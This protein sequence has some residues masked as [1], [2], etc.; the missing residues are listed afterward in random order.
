MKLLLSILIFGASI[1]VAQADTAKKPPVIRIDPS[2]AVRI[3]YGYPAWNKSPTEIDSGSL[4]MR[5]KNSGRLV[6]IH[7]LETEPDSSAFSGL[8]SIN[9]QNVG[10]MQADFFIPPQ[11]LLNSPEGMKQISTMIANGQ[12]LRKPFIFRR[13]KARG[14]SVEIFDTRDQARSAMQAYVAEQQ[15]QGLQNDK[16]PSDSQVDT[17]ALAVHLKAKEEAAKAAAER[18]RLEQIEAQ[19]I[20]DL[21]A[22]EAAIQ[23][24]E[25]ARRK[26]EGEQL[27][28]EALASYRDGKFSEAGEKFSKAIELDPENH[29]YYFQYGV[30]LYKTENFN[31]SL[32]YLNLAN[33]PDVNQVE[34]NFYLGLNYFRLKEFESA[35]KSFDQVAGGNDPTM[36]PSAQFYKGVVFFEEK[37]WEESR[38]AFQKVLDTSKDPKLDERAENYIEQ[39]LRLRQFELEKSRK[40][41]ISAT[42]GEQYDSNVNLISDSSLSQGSSTDTEGLR[43]LLM[44]SL[45]YRPIYSETREWSVQLDSLYLYTLDN[46]LTHSPTLRNA[47]PWVVTLSSPWTHKGLLWGKGYKLDITPGYE[48][49]SM[50]IVDGTQ[51][52]IISSFYVNVANMFV[53]GNRLFSNFNIELRN[54]ANQIE[55]LKGDDDSSALKVKLLNSNLHF[56]SDD[57]SKIM[58]SELSFTTNSATGKNAVYNRL[59]AALGWIQPFYWDT[60][61]TAK[62]GYFILNYPNRSDS[63]ADNNLT[64]TLGG[65]KKINETFSVGLVG[66][67]NDNSSN[68][69]PYVYKK[70]T[71]MLTL[72]ALRA[73]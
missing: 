5:E 27:S 24:E 13:S 53:M 2:S 70:W 7:L 42:I 20:A 40:W 34:K 3:I 36:A 65:N 64:L 26:Q 41:R 17:A 37:K 73:F 63:R 25:K 22:R 57:K 45:R 52:Q 33:S 46:S 32:V 23:K 51:K 30:S 10:G 1:A 12:L 31:K 28:A 59:D 35:T 71:T 6:Q 47:D 4:I 16:Y 9:W 60:T 38:N 54:D 69:R 72:S 62:L 29:S 14:Q 39:I 48:S 66:S 15:V 44:G 61:A 68:S 49:I 55:T 43:T 67:Y 19:R 21:K 18:V 11:N 8:Y 50:G 58:T 56:M